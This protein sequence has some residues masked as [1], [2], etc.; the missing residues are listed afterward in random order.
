MNEEIAGA[1]TT[2]MLEAAFGGRWGVWLSDSGYWW[3]ARRAALSP[4]ELSAGCIPFLRAE[5]PAQLA[6]R[7][8][9]QEELSARIADYPA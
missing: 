5:A 8:R 1:C 6:E 7:I 9:A 3:A 2:G 4:A